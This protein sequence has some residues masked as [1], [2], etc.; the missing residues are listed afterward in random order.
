M[1]NY[2]HRKLL[3]KK[4]DFLIKSFSGLVKN[5]KIIVYTKNKI[6][7]ELSQSIWR[8]TKKKRKFVNNLT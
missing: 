8:A 5:E 1:I 7:I 6:Y 3:P 2:R 4:A